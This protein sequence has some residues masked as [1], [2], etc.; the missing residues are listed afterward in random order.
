[1]IGPLVKCD[2]PRVAA[3]PRSSERTGVASDGDAGATSLG[4]SEI[5]PH[6][7]HCTFFPRASSSTRKVARQSGQTNSIAISDSAAFQRCRLSMIVTQSTFFAYFEDWIMALRQSLQ[8]PLTFW[9]GV[10]EV[11]LFQPA[12]NTDACCR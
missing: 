3:S 4:N 9:Y 12:R 6:C 11:L 5:F 1:M 7:G 2:S 10:A 8:C